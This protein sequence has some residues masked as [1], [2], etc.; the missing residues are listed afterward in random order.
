M[1]DE[2]G[3]GKATAHALATAGARLYL[4]CRNPERAEQ[5][6]AELC[7]LTGSETIFT[8][9][10]DVSSLASIA[11]LVD[12]FPEDSIDRLVHNAGV[13]PSEK[14]ESPDGLELT[15]ATNVVGPQLMTLLF[16][17]KLRASAE[18][19]VVWVSS[20]GMLGVKLNIAQLR[21]P[22]SPFNGVQAYAQ[23]KRA[24]AILTTLWDKRWA[25][26]SVRA[27]SMHP[28]WAD[29]PAVASSIPSFHK[30]MEK[31]LRSPAQ[32]ADTVI[33]LCLKPMIDPSGAYWFDRKVANQHP[34]LWT[35]ETDTVQQQLWEHV[36]RDLGDFTHSN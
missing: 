23:T 35:R 17:P 36:M 15:Y 34:L 31:R 29:T 22:K 27:H 9:I 24:Q 18:S 33:W 26:T 20:G 19:R 5:A 6:R 12:R 21:S 3:I 13:L 11:A 1:E 10:V 25:N 7:S 4:L 30:A 14:Y 16:E 8:E 32:G 28:G 2:S